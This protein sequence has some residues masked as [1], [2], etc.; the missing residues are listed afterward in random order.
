MDETPS[1]ALGTVAMSPLQLATAYTTFATLGQTAEPRFVLR[2]E[3]E[4]GA[5]CGRHRAAGAAR[6]GPGVA[7]VVTDILRDA[8]DYG[9]GTGVR[10][11]GFRGVAAGK[12]GTTNNATDA[13]FVGYTPDVVGAVWIG[14][15][16]PS[17]LGS[18]ATGGGF[19]APVWGR[20]MRQLY[21]ER[22]APQAWRCRQVCWND[23]SIRTRAWCCRTAATPAGRAN[24]RKSSSRSMYRRAHARSAISGAISGVASAGIRRR[25][26]RPAGRP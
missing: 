21:S 10:T 15:D 1:L 23:G 25:A 6:H 7:Y 8:V 9:T 3:D 4:T 5:A 20:I 17:S 24:R 16:R 26:K 2:V 14:Y 12:T 18:A 19:A 22:P 13:W 11:P